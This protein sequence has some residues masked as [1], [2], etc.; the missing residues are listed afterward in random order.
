MTVG[1]EAF[2]LAFDDPS[3]RVFEQFTLSSGSFYFY[4]AE[5]TSDIWVMDLVY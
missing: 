4:V 3:A 2:G 1:L 5:F